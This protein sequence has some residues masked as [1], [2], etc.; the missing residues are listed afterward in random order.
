MLASEVFIIR[1]A[2]LADAASIEALQA[3]SFRALSAGDYDESASEA[4]LALMARHGR[5]ALGA[6]RT[7]VAVYDGRI[8]ASGGWTAGP[9]SYDQYRASSHGMDGTERTAA[10]Q[11]LYVDPAVARSGIAGRLLSHIEIQARRAGFERIRLAT[12]Y[13]AMPFFTRM[14]YRPSS[15][16]SLALPDGGEIH[17]A[18]LAKPLTVRL[19]ASLAAAA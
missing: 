19:V 9:A 12:A 18:E 14:G 11:G 5:D 10:L 8:L 6:G 4:L 16:V 2:T 17:G 15:L 3:A 13:A 1:Q 7:Y